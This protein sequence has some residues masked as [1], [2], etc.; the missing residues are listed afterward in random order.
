I[1]IAINSGLLVGVLAMVVAAVTT[2]P[3]A[4]LYERGAATVWAPALVHAAIDS[5]RVVSVPAEATTTFSLFVTGLALVVPMLVFPVD[6]AL[7]RVSRPARTGPEV[8]A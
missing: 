7:A 1:P 2:L 3:L 8:A 6:W 5:F 4:F